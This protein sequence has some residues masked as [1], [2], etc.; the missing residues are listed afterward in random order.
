M[1]RASCVFWLLT[2]TLLAAGGP[3]EDEPK[4]EPKKL[5]GW[6]AV[7]NPS[8]ECTVRADE[9]ALVMRL[10]AGVHDLWAGRKDESKRF[11]APRVL[12]EVEGD[13]VARVKVTT[14]GPPRLD[15][16]YQGAGLV[17]WDSE[18]QYVRLERNFCINNKGEA[19]SFTCPLY[20]RDGKRLSKV[21]AAVRFFRGRSTW[22]RLERTGQRVAASFS[23]DG[24][25]WTEP[26]VVVTALPRSVRVGVHAINNSDAAFVARFEDFRVLRD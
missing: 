9:G 1:F 14:D 16:F 19:F 4:D 5:S 21:T 11:N 10:P 12:R 15:V 20:D 26:H 23:H 2:G 25:A 3:P 22:L 7:V 24:E 6:G 17:I 13:F 18:A 8:R